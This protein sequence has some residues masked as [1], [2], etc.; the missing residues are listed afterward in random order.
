MAIARTAEV[1]AFCDELLDSTSFDDWSPNG[2]QVFGASETGMVVTGVSARLELFERAA[3]LGAG[4]VI[5][6]H[7]I[8]HGAG[9]PIDR[10]QGE[11]LKALLLP[12]IALAQYHLP[13]DAHPTIGNNALLAEG[14]GATIAGRCCPV[15]GREIGVVAE[16]PGGIPAAELVERVERLCANPPLA[17]LEGPDMVRRIA[18]VSGAASGEVS[19]VAALGLD[20]LLTGAPSESSVPLA[21]EAGIHLICAGH[22]ATE[23]FGISRLGDAVAERFGIEHRFIDI[24]NPV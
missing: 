19:T 6:H 24:P 7:G 18:I 20:G 8:L 21:A 10:L 11:R 23:T 15:R 3:E 22:H 2:L 16:F 17:L 9:G 13:L 12:G 5:A 14:L 1:I 4:L